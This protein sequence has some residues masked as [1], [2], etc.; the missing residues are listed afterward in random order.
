MGGLSKGI[1]REP[2]IKA[3]HNKVKKMYCFG[4]EAS[5]LHQLCQQ[6]SL[7]SQHFSTLDEAFYACITD[8]RPGDCV[9]F[10]PAGSSFDLFK[11][12]QERGNHFKQLAQA[13]K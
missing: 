2:L 13:I 5:V 1:D 7:S 11:N 10:S 8:L 6:Y 4:T 12:Y 3:L 9:L